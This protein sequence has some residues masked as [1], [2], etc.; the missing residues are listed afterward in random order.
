MANYVN[1]QVPDLVL[2]LNLVSD[3]HNSAAATKITLLLK[4][5]SKVDKKDQHLVPG[6]DK[7]STTIK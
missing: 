6:I 5:Q 3:G 1:K 2:A 4:I 7:Q